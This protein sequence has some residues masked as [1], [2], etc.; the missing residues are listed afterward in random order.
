VTLGTT[1]QRGFLRAQSRQ[2]TD[3]SELFDGEFDVLVLSPS[4]DSRCTSICGAIRMRTRRAV[5]LR[6]S[7]SDAEGRQRAHR[8]VLE[9]FAD[10]VSKGS[11]A[12]ISGDSKEISAFWSALL[13]LLARERVEVGRPLRVAFDASSC[14]RFLTA[15][16]LGTC[17]SS[18]LASAVSIFYAEGVYPERA[19]S[20]SVAFSRGKWETVAVPSFL[21][22]YDPGKR[23]LYLVSVG[24]EGHKTLRAVNAA[25]PDRVSILLPDPGVQD[26]YVQRAIDSNRQLIESYCIPDDQIVRVAAGD[27][28]AAWKALS[29]RSLEDPE[30]ENVYY[31][32]CGTKPH[33]IGMALNALTLGF[34]A[35]LYNIPE[36]HVAVS[37]S[38]AGLFWRYDVIDTTAV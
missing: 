34:P 10:L 24:F 35:L 31:L 13:E 26:G 9:V 16:T 5:V 37:I 1:F 28:V 12:P 33:A 2:S 17:L 18:G 36:E 21:G 3:V 14:P 27:A 7:V 6:Y 20:Q 25:D 30:N 38:A 11:V 22:E 4:W 29:E 23:R 8:E 15:A 19:G 32:C